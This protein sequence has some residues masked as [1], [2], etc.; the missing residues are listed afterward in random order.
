MAGD[1]TTGRPMIPTNI[2]QLHGT[3]RPH[4]ELGNEP[5]PSTEG[6]KM[7]S[8]LSSRAKTHWV[9][10][11]PK[12]KEAGVMTVM[13]THALGMYC[14]LYAV[15]VQAVG[16]LEKD[17]VIIESERGHVRSPW[18]DVS[19]KTMEQMKKMLTEFGMTPA[20]RP[21][22]VSTKRPEEKNAWSDF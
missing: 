18:F 10:I 21:R 20:S 16:E 15:W 3:R 22:I 8:G 6:I 4:R 19:M 14:E 5:M 12:L 11:V 9:D 2:K 13:D 7:P 1:S 17:G